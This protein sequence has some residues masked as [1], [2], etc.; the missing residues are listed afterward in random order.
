MF[1][2]SRWT[3]AFESYAKVIACSTLNRIGRLPAD[4]RLATLND[5]DSF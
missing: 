1:E 5:D 2:E 3:V 4:G